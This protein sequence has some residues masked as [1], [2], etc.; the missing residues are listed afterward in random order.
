MEVTADRTSS[1][2]DEANRTRTIPIHTEKENRMM[3]EAS[4]R[5]CEVAERALNKIK[6]YERKLQVTVLEKLS[7]RRLSGNDAFP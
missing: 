7:R 4:D 2:S 1:S 6:F 3:I 5:D